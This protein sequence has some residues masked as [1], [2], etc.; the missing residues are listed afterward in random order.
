MLWLSESLLFSTFAQYQE[1]SGLS[2]S[3]SGQFDFLVADHP[4]APRKTLRSFGGLGL[5]VFEPSSGAVDT[6]FAGLWINVKNLAP[7]SLDELVLFQTYNTSYG[8]PE[9]TVTVVSQ[10]SSLGKWVFRVD[11]AKRLGQTAEISEEE[12]HF[13]EIGVHH[14][15]TDGW[16]EIRLD[17]TRLIRFD[18]AR[19][20]VTAPA[21]AS[22]GKV[23]F[24]IDP[25]T[26]QIEMADV[27]VAD[28]SG[29]AP[30]N[31]FLG[32]WAAHAVTLELVN[33]RIGW[34]VVTP[35]NLRDFTSPTAVGSDM[36]ASGVASLG[37]SPTLPPLFAPL[38]ALTRKVSVSNPAQDIFAYLDGA[39]SLWMPPVA[40]GTSALAHRTEL[41]VNEPPE[42]LWGSSVWV[43]Q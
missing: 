6:V 13:L 16:V 10:A 37:G 1:F 38:V 27:Y 7:S 11:A 43:I 41:A 8:Y 21:A 24:P 4:Q 9:V 39:A 3:Y 36:T 35:E 34:T 15:A 26:Y 12:W 25:S 17:G 30:F 29:A 2:G 5:E 40:L 18:N 23:L 33:E 31:T 28:S 20:Y 32:P 19:T 14:H 22:I 42:V